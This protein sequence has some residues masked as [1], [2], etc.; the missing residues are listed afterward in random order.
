MAEQIPPESATTTDLLDEHLS[1]ELFVLGVEFL[2]GAFE[3]ELIQN[4]EM[5]MT[6]QPLFNVLPR[7]TETLLRRRK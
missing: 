5:M 3:A 1:H 2:D 7:N 6:R 4:G